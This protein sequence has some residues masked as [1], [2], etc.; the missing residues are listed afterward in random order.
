MLR[1]VV[2]GAAVT[3]L[4]VS[5]MAVAQEQKQGQSPSQQPAQDANA[6]AQQQANDAMNTDGGRAGRDE[7]GAHAPTTN[8]P[9]LK[10]GKL[11]VP[12]GE[13]ISPYVPENTK[14]R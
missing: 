12:G 14:S 13:R 3:A 5:S 4:L 1:S 9:V 10:N 11:N 2:A 6:I 7:P 8:A